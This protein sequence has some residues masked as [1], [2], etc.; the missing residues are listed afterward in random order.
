MSHIKSVDSRSKGNGFQKN[1]AD[2]PIQTCR[3]QTTITVSRA[4]RR[5]SYWNYC[6]R[7]AML[8]GV[9]NKRWPRRCVRHLENNAKRFSGEERKQNEML[10]NIPADMLSIFLHSIWAQIELGWCARRK[11]I[12]L[13]VL[14]N[15]SELISRSAVFF[16]SAHVSHTEMPTQTSSLI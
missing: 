11:L 8:L 9:N 10:G 5:P 12:P 6:A 7:P 4:S 15:R 2:F 14:I 13:C 1:R 3:N 16:L